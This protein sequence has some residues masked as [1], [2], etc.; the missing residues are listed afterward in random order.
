M[1]GS[2]AHR[3]ATPGEASRLHLERLPSLLEK[4]VDSPVRGFVYEP[5]TKAGSE[6]EK[7]G[8]AAV[9]DAAGR[10]QIPV[11]LLEGERERPALWAA[12]L[13]DQV[14]AAVGIGG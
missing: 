8:R 2:W 9:A 13:A 11:C 7:G 6:V 12:M 5:A 10:W 14:E 3:R 1:P 4:L